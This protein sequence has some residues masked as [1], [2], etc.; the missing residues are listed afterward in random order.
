MI[1]ITLLSITAL[2]FLLVIVH[3]LGHYFAARFFHIKIEQVCIGFGRPLLC[4]RSPKTHIEY[5]L[6][7]WP[8]GGGVKLEEKDSPESFNQQ[9]YGKRIGVLL[10]GSIANLILAI[11]LFTAMYMYGITHFK[12]IIGYIEPNSI[13]ARANLHPQEQILKVDGEPMVGWQDVLLA[14]YRR[15]GETTSMQLEILDLNKQIKSIS[16]NL[17]TWPSQ[18]LKSSPIQS[19]GIK[20]YLPHVIPQVLSQKAPQTAQH[21]GLQFNDKIIKIN[22]TLIY[23]WQ[24]VMDYFTTHAPHDYLTLTLQRHGKL[25]QQTVHLNLFD[26]LT[27]H[28]APSQLLGIG[29]AKMQWPKE[30]LHYLQYPFLSSLLVSLKQTLGFVNFNYVILGK[31]ISGKLPFYNLGGP[32]SLLQNAYV[33]LDEGFAIFLGFAALLSISLAVVNLLPIPGLDGGHLLFL[34]IA[35]LRKKPISLSVQFLA[36]RLG[37]IVILMLVAN[38]LANDLRHLAHF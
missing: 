32:L 22:K 37:I 1:L 29:V 18:P 10:S 2:F 27:W 16:L 30:T 4:Y 5:I 21:F 34:F 20:P 33:A 15:V 38:M 23:D 7:L 13:A 6:K 14:M 8:F 36:Y 9:T 12:A 35:W 17:K 19:L 26:I 31:L 24:D 11:L 25:I 3:E 28:F